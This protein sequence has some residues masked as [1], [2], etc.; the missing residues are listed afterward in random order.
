LL[1]EVELE[2][3]DLMVKKKWNALLNIAEAKSLEYKHVVFRKP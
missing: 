2:S 1:K 3:V